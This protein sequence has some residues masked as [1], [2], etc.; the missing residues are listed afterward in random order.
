VEAIEYP[1]DLG[2]LR[3]NKKAAFLLNTLHYGPS[4][5]DTFDFSCIEVYFAEK[6]PKRDVLE[7]H[8]GTQGISSVAPEF[9][10]PAGKKSSFKTKYKLRDS[11]S[12]LTVNPHMHLLGT[13]FEA[14]AFSENKMDTIPLIRI[15][16]WDFRWQ[17]FYTYPKMLVIPKGYTIQVEAEFDNTVENPFNPFNPPKT[18][19]GAGKNMKTTDEMFQFFLNYVTY[20]KGDEEI[21]L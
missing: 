8:L 13:T 4:P 15:P 21:Q 5:L 2:G 3:V 16:K 19:R 18:L 6:R 12:V 1:E 7:L 17:F 20:K 9:I 14:Y 10:L 11:I